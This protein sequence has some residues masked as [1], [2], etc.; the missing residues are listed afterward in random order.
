[1]TVRVP[2]AELA[3]K[4]AEIEAKQAAL[5]EE[6]GKAERNRQEAADRLL[7]VPDFRPS[8][9]RLPGR[10]PTAR[11]VSATTG[12]SASTR[13]RACTTAGAT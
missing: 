4:P 8:E 10:M 3:A 5:G 12:W 1:M 2:L 13:S 11:F 9:A 6:I 7:R